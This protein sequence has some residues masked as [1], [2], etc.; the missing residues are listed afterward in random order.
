MPADGRIKR[1]PLAFA[2]ASSRSNNAVSVK[3]PTDVTNRSAPCSSTRWPC[4]RTASWPA[5]SATA[6]KAWAKKRSGW[7]VGRPVSL[8]GRFTSAATS[9]IFSRWPACRAASTC[10]PMAP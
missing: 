5:H 7:W 9:S 4:A 1:L 10:L 6:S 3:A 8:R 2:T